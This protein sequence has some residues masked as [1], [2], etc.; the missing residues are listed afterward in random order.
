MEGGL[1]GCHSLI[2]VSLLHGLLAPLQGAAVLVLQGL[3]VRHG[4][5]A[6]Q[7]QT[8]VV[9]TCFRVWPVCDKKVEKQHDLFIILFFC[10]ALRKPHVERIKKDILQNL[11]SREHK[12]KEGIIKIGCPW[13]VLQS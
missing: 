1:G 6:L 11:S 2:E 9:V 8:L 10:S 12:A 13:L 4:L 5:H 7:L 3:Q